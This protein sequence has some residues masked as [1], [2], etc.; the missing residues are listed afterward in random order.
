MKLQRF[1]VAALATIPSLPAFAQA[2]GS[3]LDAGTAVPALRYDSAFADYRRDEDLPRADWRE[4]NRVVEEA[5]RP[6][7][8]HAGQGAAGR[9]GDDATPPGGRHPG[10]THRGQMNPGQMNHG[11]MNHGGANHGAHPGAHGASK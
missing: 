1:V 4:A 11:A 3:P 10:H 8:G 2:A 9:P 6:G 5:A 7:G